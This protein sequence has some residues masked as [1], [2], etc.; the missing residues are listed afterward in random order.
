MKAKQYRQGDVL[1]EEIQDIPEDCER[2]K[3]NLIVAG[4][5]SDHGHFIIN[6]ELLEMGEELFIDVAE[7]AELKHLTIS[8][9][10]TTNEHHTIQIPKG[11]YKVINQRE[12]DPYTESTKKIVD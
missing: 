8:T 4:E 12:Y 10:D 1:V 5:V 9:K 3:D 6:A 7:Q 11:K 2:R